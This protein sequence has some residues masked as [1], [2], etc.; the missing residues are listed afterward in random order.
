MEDIWFWTAAKYDIDQALRYQALLD[1][2]LDDLRLEPERPS[3]IP[4][5]EL[6]TGVRS[7]HIELSKHRS[8]TG[9][10]SP[11]HVI[12]YALRMADEVLVLR[13]VHDR[14]NLRRQRLE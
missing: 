12:I 11:R 9:I 7:Y 4:R 6:G 1:Q 13:I 10:K 8:G 14:M 5:P 3:S 2:A